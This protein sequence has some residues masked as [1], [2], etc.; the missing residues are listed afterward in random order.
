MSNRRNRRDR[1]YACT[2]ARAEFVRRMF[3]DRVVADMTSHSLLIFLLADIFA[4]ISIYHAT[5][6]RRTKLS[7]YI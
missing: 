7:R 4:G 1:L 5:Q 2:R 6:A 3:G